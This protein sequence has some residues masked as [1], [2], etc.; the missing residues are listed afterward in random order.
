M[1]ANNI[2]FLSLLEIPLLIYDFK[3]MFDINELNL[4]FIDPLDLVVNSFNKYLNSNKL[5]KLIFS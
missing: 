4:M 3:N 2:I 1:N 5:V